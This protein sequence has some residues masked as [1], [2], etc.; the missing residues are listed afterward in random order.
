[1]FP[2]E[3][4]HCDTVRK[5]DIRQL[6]PSMM[7]GFLIKSEDDLK[8]FIRRSED[9]TSAAS[10]VFD[11]HVTAPSYVRSAYRDE[12]FSLGLAKHLQK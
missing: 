6:D 1:M 4:Y 5:A 8:D 3:S 11:I 10:K 9:I 7:L 12:L 2:V